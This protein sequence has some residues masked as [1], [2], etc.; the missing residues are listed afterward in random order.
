MDFVSLVRKVFIN[1]FEAICGDKSKS[2][3][4]GKN[5]LK[6]SALINYMTGI[7]INANPGLHVA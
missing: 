3:L 6:K 7:K 2:K 1:Y 4:K 5:A